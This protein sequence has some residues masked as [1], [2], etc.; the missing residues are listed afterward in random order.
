MLNYQEI[1]NFVFLPSSV[2]TSKILSCRPDLEKLSLIL[3]EPPEGCLSDIFYLIMVTQQSKDMGKF[4]KKLSSL[5]GCHYKSETAQILHGCTG[6]GCVLEEK[7]MKSFS[8]MT[9]I[10]RHLQAG[11]TAHSFT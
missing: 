5:C 3:L 10:L 8:I 4:V 6:G 2:G 11:G 1:I 7:G 9:T